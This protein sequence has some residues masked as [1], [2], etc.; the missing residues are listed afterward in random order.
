MAYHIAPPTANTGDG[1]QAQAP[2]AQAKLWKKGAD[3][4][5]QSNDFFQEMEGKGQ[6]SIIQTETD[7][8]KGRGQEI[9]F[10]VKSGFY[11]EPHFGD[12]LFEDGDHYEETK[13][14]SYK[15]VVDWVRHATRHNERMEEFM[16]MR[17]EIV[18]G[19]PADLGAWLGRLKTEQLTMMFREKI[20]P[21]NELVAGGK[22]VDELG[23]ADTLVWD[24]IVAMGTQMKPLGG[25]PAKVGKGNV[26]RQCVMATTDALFSLKIDDDYKT[27]LREADNRGKNNYIF[28][29]QF[30]DVDGHI[31]KPY[32]PI[33]H[34]GDGAI[35]SPLNPKAVNDEAI[36]AG[37]TAVTLKGGS[38]TLNRVH[39]FKYFRGYA[40]KFNEGDIL[41]APTTDSYVLAINPTNT[42]DPATAGKWCMYKY[43]T[44]NNGN[45]IVTTERLAAADSGVAKLKVGEVTWNANL[46]TEDIVKGAMIIQVNAKGVPIGDTLMFGRRAAY[47]GY[48]K[49]RNHRSTQNHEGGFVKDLY[50]TSVFGQ[51]IVKDRLG[52]MPGVVKITHALN[53]P[54]LRLPVIA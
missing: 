22:T 33:D 27:V 20:N 41:A 39:Y 16:G 13:L 51:E 25:L 30:S 36:P 10:K 38:G 45:V 40:Y 46:N 34:D 11:A 42:G 29:G 24:E 52:R 49:Y 1:M 4:F 14:S 37:T 18:G 48:G 15:M 23:S 53:I 3:I 21:E 6:N 47:R 17:G 19:L 7:T 44:G 5:E 9:E 28:G 31:I 43:T 2:D 54:G 35:G 50:I 32:N 12:E 8:S 26:W